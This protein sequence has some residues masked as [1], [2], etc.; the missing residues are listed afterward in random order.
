MFFLVGILFGLLVQEHAIL[1]GATALQKDQ[2]PAVAQ[3]AV[4]A[5]VDSIIQRMGWSK[6]EVDL[7][8]ID[9]RDARLG[10]TLIYEFDIRVGDV[11]IPLRLSEEITSWQYLDELPGSGSENLEKAGDEEK[12][13][14]DVWRPEAFDAVLAPFQ[15]AGPVDLWIQDAEE[16]R[17]SMPHDVDAGKLKKVVLADGAVVTVR[18][19]REV[20]LS[21]PLQLPLPLAQSPEGK[22][23]AASLI[24]LASRLRSASLGHGTPLLS[25]RI[26]GPTSL[27]AAVA[28]TEASEPERARLKVKR[29][30]SGAVELTSPSSKQVV[31]QSGPSGALVS[32]SDSMGEDTWMWPLPL[33][34]MSKLQALEQ[35]L[36]KT[37]GPSVYKKGSFQLL[38]AKVSA[39]SFVQMQ[40]ELEKKVTEESLS[41]DEF[42]P[43]WATKPS[44]ERLEFELLAK[45]E[46]DR[47]IPIR[48]QH[49][50]PVLPTIAISPAANIDANFTMKSPAFLPP[51]GAMTLDVD[52]EGIMD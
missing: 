42:W 52:W 4:S 51:P 21:R 27:T 13:A 17:L 2:T 8:R 39:A 16:L 10:Q 7:S 46:G 34:N 41:S 5:T 24:A 6:D 38:K 18:G 45:V 26:V 11:I 1:M 20:S 29:L 23:L 36:I 25:L 19:A 33:L 35:A 50:E 3:E 22:G 30:G 9:T 14:I 12:G 49:L 31:E 43:D 28:P 44:V 47:L 32:L 37:L 40:F 48:A 15:V